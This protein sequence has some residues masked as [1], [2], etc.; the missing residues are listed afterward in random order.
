MK[1]FK[2]K[3]KTQQVSVVGMGGIKFIRHGLESFHWQDFYH[4]LFTMSWAKLFGAI[5]LAYIVLNIFFAC[6]YAI[7]GD[8][9]ANAQPGYFPDAFFFSVQTMA[10]I[11]YGAMY[12]TTPYSNF[13]VFVE[14][15]VGLLGVAMATGLMFARFSVPSA[16]VLFSKVAVICPYN[17][18]PT[19]IFRTANQR[20]NLILES[21]ITVTILMPEITP[22]GHNIR[23][24]HDLKLVRSNTPI[25]SLSWMV[26][27]PIDEKSPLYGLTSE[28]LAELEASIIVTLTGLDETVSQTIHSRY[29]YMNHDILW[30]MRF[31]DVI[32]TLPNGDRKINYSAF[33]D[34]VDYS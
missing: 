12:P 9:I 25:F 4:L 1:S 34:V 29:M 17:Q 13:L 7:G 15:F 32:E 6:A 23:R 5:S 19:L 21:Q 22:E 30:N 14:V 33:H 2:T 27:H 24:L 28:D 10:T 8:C 16:R 18:I 20:N 11:G 26:M 31:V 3:R